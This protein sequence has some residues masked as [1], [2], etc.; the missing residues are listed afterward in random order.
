MV[1]IYF[2]IKRLGADWMENV[3]FDNCTTLI[4]CVE[5]YTYY[6]DKVSNKDRALLD[7][8]FY[9]YVHDELEE[10]LWNSYKA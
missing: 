2:T 7:W 9:S 8:I 3:T 4:E 10:D 1:N 6:K 5:R